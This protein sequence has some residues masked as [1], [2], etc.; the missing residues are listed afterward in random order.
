MKRKNYRITLHGCLV[1]T[2][3]AWNAAG[4]AI[5]D[6]VRELAR[7]EGQGYTL[8]ETHG[9][10]DADGDFISGYRTWKGDRDGM[11]VKFEIQK[12]VEP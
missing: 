1:E 3:H 11:T 5:V 7:K 2:R 9:V 12:E 10:K 6:L 8:I 4:R